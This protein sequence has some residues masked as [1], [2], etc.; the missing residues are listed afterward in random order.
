MKNIIILNGAARKN[1]NTSKLIKS[2]KEGAESSGNHVRE[3]Y[4]HNM[5]INGCIGCN[6]C[7]EAMNKDNPCIQK[8]DMKDIYMAFKESDV[9]VFASPVYFWTITG[10]LKTVVDR[11]YAEFS[12]FG[13]EAS[14]KE[15][16]LIMTAGGDDYSQPTNWYQLFEKYVNW[17]NIGEVLGS[18]KIKEARELG[19]SI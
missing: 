14:I 18:D 11:L 19:E 16:V 13:N 8:D 15:S 1:G 7:K 6:K 2:F 17:K 12:A 5:N 9:V 10:V 4:L 3:F